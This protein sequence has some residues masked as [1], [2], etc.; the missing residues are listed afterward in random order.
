MENE[1]HRISKKLVSVEIE[2]NNHKSV[3][4]CECVTIW[5]RTPKGK[6][7]KHLSVMSRLSDGTIWLSNDEVLTKE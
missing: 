6:I 2:T 3:T 7:L 1:K 4:E 5:I